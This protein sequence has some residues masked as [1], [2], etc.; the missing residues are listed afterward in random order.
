VCERP[1]H[2]LTFLNGPVSDSRLAF[3][4]VSQRCSLVPPDLATEVEK[5]YCKTTY[6]AVISMQFK[7]F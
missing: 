2:W 5:K 1:T 6:V 3:D 7:Q 4:E